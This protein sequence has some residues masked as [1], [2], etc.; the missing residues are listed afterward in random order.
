[1]RLPIYFDARWNGPHGIGRFAAEI[2]QRLSGIE[3]LPIMVRKL[4]PLDPLAISLALANKRQGCYFPPGFNLPLS[5]PIPV[6]FTIHDLIHIKVPE[7][8]SAIRRLYYATVVRPAAR[9]GWK[10]LT[11]SLHSRQDIAEWA[12]IPETVISVV[13]NGVSSVFSSSGLHHAPGYPYLLHVGRRTGHKNI[14]RLLAAFSR[15]RASRQLKLIFTGTPDAFTLDIAQ[16]YG[17]TARVAFSGATDDI[18]LARIYRG[19]TALVF[20]SLYEGFGLPVVEAMACGT[21]VI[22]SDATATREVAGIGNALLVPPKDIDALT[23]AIDCIVDDSVLR[24][25]LATRGLQRARV[26][27]WSDV[28]SRVIAALEIPH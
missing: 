14:E 1:M 9:R 3:T 26:F 19:A 8:S 15:S 12:G 24:I 16:R 17:L 10:I 7:E 5:S 13:G 22:T 28:A 20:P 25:E 11:V 23:E 21:P 27:A 18:A 2:Q 6:I 4:S